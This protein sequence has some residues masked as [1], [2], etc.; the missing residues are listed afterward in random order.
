MK[1]TLQKLRKKPLFVLYSGLSDISF[2]LLYSFIMTSLANKALEYAIAAGSLTAKGSSEMGRLVASSHTLLQAIA[3]V[4]GVKPLLIDL[5][6][7]GA[8]FMLS[9]FI[10]YIFFQGLSWY[11]AKMLAGHVDYYEFMIRFIKINA[12]WLVFYLI[13]SIIKFFIKFTQLTS[14]RPYSQDMM[15]ISII[16]PILGLILAYFMVFSYTGNKS[17]KESIKEGLT[18][19]KAKIFKFL[20]VLIFISLIHIIQLLIFKSTISI[21]PVFS[22]IF[23]IFVEIP[24]LTVARVFLLEGKI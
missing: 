24:A 22:G 12:I 16:V 20:A 4:D 7:I 23:F 15:N 11:C 14:G 3:S 6:L 21:S 8:V 1:A 13:L 18:R 10:L 2:I 5:F 17:L 9:T 19:P